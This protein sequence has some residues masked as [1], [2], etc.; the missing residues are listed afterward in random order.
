MSPRL[1]AGL[2]ALGLVVALLAPAVQ[3]PADRGSFRPVSSAVLVC[4]QSTSTGGATTALGAMVAR[5]VPG[6]GTAFLRSIQPGAELVRLAEVGEPVALSAQS[7]SQPAMIMQADGAWAPTSFAGIAAHHR[8]GASQGLASA[9]CLAPAPEWWFVGGG[10]QIG[11]GTALLVSNPSEE[12]AR[13]DLV[14]HAGGGPIA[15]LGG[16]GIDVGPGASVRLRMDALAPG[17]SL[18]AIQVRATIGR[19][20]AALRDVAVPSADRPR[21]VD[22]VP[23]AAAPDTRLVVAGIPGG[24]GRRELVLVNP[25]TQFATVTPR[26]LTETGSETLAE[27]RSIAVPAGAVVKVDLDRVL[28]GRAGSLAMTSDV[29]VTGGASAEWGARQR[30]VVWLS[31][32]PP[33]EDPNPMGAAAG[34]PSFSGL[35]TTVVIAA[36]DGEVSGTL[37]VTSVESADLASFGESTSPGSR[38]VQVA[39]PV[40]DGHTT[41]RA[42]TV[43]AASQR[44]VTIPSGTGGNPGDSGLRTIVWRSQEGSGPAW[45]T[46]L[47]LAAEVPLAT[48]YSWWPVVS[49]VVSVDVREDVGILAPTGREP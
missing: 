7:Q 39:L 47:G 40:G 35:D 41:V 4:P 21:G 17:E 49:S 48:G 25:G 20:A 44:T 36:T 10:S 13:F 30:D 14:L 2:V 11:R 19:V 5:P 26:F 29:A 34:V 6:P 22:F 18:L 15:A 43:P 3:Q 45:V 33:I 31:A 1:L 16:K 27:L 37:T 38:G 23:P 8:S 42:L 32:V 12:P 28:E 9:A 24:P 46:H